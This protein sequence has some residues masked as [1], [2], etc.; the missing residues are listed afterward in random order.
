MH[1][2]RKIKVKSLNAVG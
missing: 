2:K 1:Y